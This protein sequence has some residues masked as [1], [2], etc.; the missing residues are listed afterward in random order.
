MKKTR[1]E[2]I[3]NFIK[4]EE[5]ITIPEDASDYITKN[6]AGVFVSLHKFNELRGCIG[7]FLPTKESIAL[8]KSVLFEYV[9]SHAFT[10]F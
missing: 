9:T 1:H 3:L 6:K 4:N 5:T 7:T 8:A 2:L 10:K